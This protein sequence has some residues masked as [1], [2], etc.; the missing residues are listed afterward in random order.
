MQHEDIAKLKK[1]NALN[2][3]KRVSHK[4][5]RS[6]PVEYEKLETALFHWLQSQEAMDP[7][8]KKRVRFLFMCPLLYLPRVQH[9]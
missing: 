3:S 2:V 4:Y 8:L 1:L 6:R 5:V 9:W 7:H